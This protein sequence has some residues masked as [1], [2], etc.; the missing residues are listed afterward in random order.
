MKAAATRGLDIS[1]LRARQVEDADFERFDLILAMD[2]SNHATLIARCPAAHRARVRL[3]LE[4]VEAPGRMDV[5][6]PYYGGAQGFD[7][8]L[9]L[10]EEAAAGLLE[11]IRRWTVS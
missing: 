3:L 6:D 7:E 5:P 11:E 2:R 9:D 4:F 8:V 1:G 10:V